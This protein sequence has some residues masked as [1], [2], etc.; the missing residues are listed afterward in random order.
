MS[1]R[2][3]MPPSLTWSLSVTY[4]RR[5]VP[6]DL[7]GWSA[8]MV[9]Q[10]FPGTT[11]L[12]TLDTG[13]AGGITFGEETGT[14]FAYVEAAPDDLTGTGSYHLHLLPPAE[15]GGRYSILC[16]YVDYST[17][18]TVHAQPGGVLIIDSDVIVE[19][20]NIPGPPGVGGG[21]GGGG[22]NLS[23]TGRTSTGLTIASDSGTDAAV[24]AATTSLAGLMV[25]ADKTKLDGVAAG[26]AA[27][28][29]A[30]TG[31]ADD[32]HAQ[33]HTDARGD[34]RYSAIGHNHTGTYDPAGTA[35]AAVSA[36]E[37][38]ADPH[39]T[40][41]TA[42]E[43]AAAAPVQSVAGRT[44]AVTLSNT[45]VSGL[46]TS[47]TL[48]HGA[49]AGNLVRLD[50]ATGKLPAVDGS[51]LTNLP[52]GGGAAA[53]VAFEDIAADKTFAASDKAEQYRITASSPVVLTFPA[54]AAAGSGWWIEIFN[55]GTSYGTVTP[56]S[57]TIDGLASYPMYP[58][59]HRRFWSDG[60]VIQSRV[61]AGYVVEL[62]A[63]ATF[64][65]PPGYSYLDQYLA[66]GGGSGAKGSGS[67]RGSGGGGGAAVLVR[68]SAATVGY[69][70]VTVTIGA[71]GAAVTASSTAGNAGGTSSFGSFSYAYGGGGGSASASAH[72]GGGG[73]GGAL[74]AGAVGL[75]TTALA[76]GGEPR[77]S[78][79]T[80]VRYSGQFGGGC[81]SSRDGGTAPGAGFWGGGGGGAAATPGGASVF[82]GGGGGGSSSAG[83]AS[84]VGGAGGAGG[85][86]TSGV[87][88]SVPGGGGGATD[89]GAASG[90][91]ADGK[92]IIW[93]II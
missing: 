53:F 39:P 18:A 57:G 33:Y 4:R 74:S 68:L 12:L 54:P 7:T 8:E 11:N 2:L 3:H 89:T 64:Y 78:D 38:A 91:G 13:D 29:G 55:A 15:I 88:G 6:V 70:P 83:G 42:A 31:L 92:A 67:F 51:L 17:C 80:T 73:G 75:T 5:G 49:A 56:A 20:A 19:S 23:V 43:A 50:P 44:G 16:G 85:T 30:L 24:P 76:L 27:D 87:A 84:R 22:A 25:A 71:G 81:G 21:G 82:G 48:D 28:H 47:A 66:G 37:G 41:T 59:E 35:A 62:L 69:S 86:S 26:A 90:A 32:D 52:G 93:G 45:D 61:I 63:S 60:S 14:L 77:S 9:F 40:Y 72:G 58:G 79:S 1:H 65:P 36:H 34:A 46:G 10:D